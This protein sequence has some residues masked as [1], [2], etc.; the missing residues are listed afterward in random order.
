MS[1]NAMTKTLLPLLVSRARCRVHRNDITIQ[2]LSVF[3]N[4]DRVGH[5]SRRIDLDGNG[6]NNACL[7][8]K[9]GHAIGNNTHL[10][11]LRVKISRVYQANM[12][13]ILFFVGLAQNQ[14]IEYLE[15]DNV[16]PNLGCFIKN[17]TNLRC[18]I[19]MYPC[20]EEFI[21]SIT[22]TLLESKV[23]RF[24]RIC[25]SQTKVADIVLAD[26]INALNAAFRLCNLS[27]LEVGWNKT[28]AW[29]GCKALGKLLEN[30]KCQLQSLTLS[31]TSINDKCIDLLTRGLLM[32]NTIKIL[33]I[34]FLARV[35]PIG[36][37]SFFSTYLANSKCSLRTIDLSDNNIGDDGLICL[38]QYIASNMNST[39][40]GLELTE[41][42]LYQEYNTKKKF[43]Y[44][45]VGWSGFSSA[46]LVGAPT[47]KIVKLDLTGADMN[48]EGG[49][50]VMSALVKIPSV[51]SVNLWDTSIGASGWAS[52]FQ[53]MIDNGFTFEE[54]ILTENNINDV[55]AALLFELL[56]ANKTLKTLDLK[57]NQDITTAGWIACFRLLLDSGSSVENLFLIPTILT[58]KVLHYWFIS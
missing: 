50:G 52:C 34:G 25:L 14:S 23:N 53:L 16:Y 43:R 35:T 48:D 12:D 57:D 11:K 31:A 26:L 45:T 7:A 51:K 38:G 37:R 20:G 10:R 13:A 5:G 56:G 8:E 21:P 42:E 6:G 1:K 15:L 3:L 44:T 54:L 33:H 41:P 2:G 29:K 39:L 46:L 17:N 36:W 22:S 55:G 9:I 24:E 47:L 49:T 28:L 30:S 19:S 4:Y 40:T 18:I 27:D 58:M 32:R